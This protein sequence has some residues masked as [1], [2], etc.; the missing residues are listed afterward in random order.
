MPM[1]AQLEARGEGAAGRTIHPVARGPQVAA[2]ETVQR[3]R[4]ATP[5]VGVPA[6]HQK[7]LPPASRGGSS[8]PLR[9]SFQPPLRAGGPFAPAATLAMAHTPRRGQTA[10]QSAADTPPHARAPVLVS[11]VALLLPTGCDGEDAGDASD[12]ASGTAL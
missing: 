11:A 5:A 10:P 1:A 7:A 4:R 6:Q 3:R 12:A 9:H 8:P 2:T